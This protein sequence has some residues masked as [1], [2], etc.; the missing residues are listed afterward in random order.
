MLFFLS[1]QWQLRHGITSNSRA[2]VIH[3]YVNYFKEENLFPSEQCEVIEQDKDGFIAIDRNGE[4]FFHHSLCAVA[5]TANA[6][7]KTNLSG[8]VV[9]VL[10]ADIS[11]ASAI[12]KL[13]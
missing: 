2:G 9:R 13:S 10:R 7:A 12:Q 11:K 1:P 8:I 6:M 3:H 4:T 5:E